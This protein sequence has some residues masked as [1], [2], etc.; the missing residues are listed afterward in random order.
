MSRD[1]H[2]VCQALSILPEPIQE[3]LRKVRPVYIAA[4]KLDTKIQ[5][6]KYFYTFLHRILN[7]EVV[8]STN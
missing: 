5:S 4:P 1:A 6:S 3:I 2:C 8:V 7:I